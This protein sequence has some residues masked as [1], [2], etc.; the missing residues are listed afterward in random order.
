MQKLISTFA[1]KSFSDD[2]VA[3][4]SNLPYENVN[5]EL[6]LLIVIEKTRSLTESNTYM[7][8]IFCEYDEILVSFF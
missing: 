5:P 6:Y 8:N 3:N 2:S 4:S 1:H 7:R